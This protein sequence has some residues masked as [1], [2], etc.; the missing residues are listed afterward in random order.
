MAVDFVILLTAFA[1]ADA[2]KALL[3]LLGA[4]ALNVVIGVNHRTDRYYGV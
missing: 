1:V 3:S 2:H 4:L